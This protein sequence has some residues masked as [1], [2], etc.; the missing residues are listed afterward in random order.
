MGTEK[1]LIGDFNSD[2]GPKSKAS[3]TS[4]SLSNFCELLNLKQLIT[5]PTRVSDATE[6]TI[7]LILTSDVSRISEN[8]V[9][10]CG[11]SDHFMVFCTRKKIKLKSVCHKTTKSR[12]TKN[13]ST[14]GFNRELANLDWS[15]VLEC[16][17][18]DEAW[19]LF[20]HN[21]TSIL[22]KIAPLKTTRI[23]T[24]SEPWMNS[25]ILTAMKTRDDKCSELL[26][27]K[28][29]LNKQPNSDLQ[30]QLGILQTQRNTLRNTVTTMIRSAKKT[31][32]NEKT[33]E[34]RN[35]PRELWKL[36]NNQLSYGHKP[37]TK[38]SNINIKSEQTLITDKQDVANHLNSFF[39]NMATTLVN[40]LPPHSGRFDNDHINS[41]Y[42][43][44][45][46]CK[47]D[48]KLT[49]VTNE[50][51]LN[52]LNALQQHKATGHDNIPAKFL[53]D[54]ASTVAPFIT[55]IVNLSIT[56]GK[57]PQDLKIAKV[58]PLHKKGSKLD[59]ANYR[60]ISILNT[61]SKVVEKIVYEQIEKYLTTNKLIYEYQSGFRTS[62]STDTC[63]LYLSDHIK[64]E[65]DAGKYCGMV[66]GHAGPS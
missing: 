45:G 57:V 53:K 13:Y 6:T 42:E 40:K 41:F 51:V 23:K 10:I 48:F 59:P 38:T 17:N 11:L 4:R 58:I 35:N 15:N 32:I 50:Q 1:I 29:N 8:G 55:H 60:P 14:E 36:L 7:D 33:E 9:I 24:H 52:K 20:K 61:I 2:A 18:V 28:L 63:L 66:I 27:C 26:K 5:K 65:L 21:F 34:N 62:H 16:T 22:D 44:L 19:H 25:D 54:S 43:N 3:P 56:Q 30:T 37:K 64:H 46:V 12:V 49:T 31:F 47:N 39:T